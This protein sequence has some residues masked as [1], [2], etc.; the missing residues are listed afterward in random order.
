MISKAANLVMQNAFPEGAVPG[1]SLASA[2]TGT[3]RVR[4]T[5]Q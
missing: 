4:P 5:K 3:S 2:Y 1:H